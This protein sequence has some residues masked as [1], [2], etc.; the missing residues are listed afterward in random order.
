MT[1]CW[2][3]FFGDKTVE[4]LEDCNKPALINHVLYCKRLCDPALKLEFIF[5]WLAL[6]GSIGSALV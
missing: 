5:A 2:S 4:C 3:N 1:L 6:L